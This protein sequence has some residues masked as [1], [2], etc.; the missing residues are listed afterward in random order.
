MQE[1]PQTQPQASQLPRLTKK[2]D[3]F[4][5]AMAKTND[6]VTAAQVAYDV[7]GPDSARAIASRLLQNAPVMQVVEAKRKTLKQALIDRGIDGDKIA[8]KVEVLL[9]ATDE[10]GNTDYNAVDKGLKHATAIYGVM[11]PEDMPKTQNIYNF[12]FTDEGRA[13]ISTVEAEIK[14][15]LT[16]APIHVQTN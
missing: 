6:P 10:D 9:E 5:T 4:A 1:E 12:V 14:E 16:K 3:L 11:S 8:E 13:R 7:N 15:A 2:Q